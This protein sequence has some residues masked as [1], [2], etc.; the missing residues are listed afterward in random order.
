MQP[1]LSRVKGPHLRSFPTISIPF[2]IQNSGPPLLHSPHDNN[3]FFLCVVLI[4][5]INMDL[6][7]PDILTPQ[8]AG[9]YSSQ[10]TG[11]GAP[12]PRKSVWEWTEAASRVGGPASFPILQLSALEASF[13]ALWVGTSPWVP[14]PLPGSAGKCSM[15]TWP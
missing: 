10:L 11:V 2:N 15:T 14:H 4:E 8:S 12:Q 3:D 13:L 1:G 9:G 5:K 7:T 6:R